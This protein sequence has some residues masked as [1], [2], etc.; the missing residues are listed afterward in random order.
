MNIYWITDMIYTSAKFLKNKLYIELQEN[1]K[2]M[3]LEKGKEILCFGSK[4]VFFICRSTMIIYFD[5]TC[6][7]HTTHA[8]ILV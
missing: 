4:F 1:A 3:V 5:G 8:D 2:F 7:V 6:D